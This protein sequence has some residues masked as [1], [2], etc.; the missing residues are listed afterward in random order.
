MNA[1]AVATGL[2]SLRARIKAAASAEDASSI[3]INDMVM[4]CVVK[5]LEAVPE[6]N[7]EFVDGKIYR[8]SRIHLG[9]ACDTPKGLLVPVIRDSQKLTLPAAG[10][11]GSRR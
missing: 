10:R 5:A 8:H 1:S 4:F 9:F 7:V 3:N 6:V 2:L 11:D